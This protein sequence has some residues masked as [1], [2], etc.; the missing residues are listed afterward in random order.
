M[1]TSQKTKIQPKT[2][3][4]KERGTF[5]SGFPCLIKL[6]VDKLAVPSSQVVKAGE[7]KKIFHNTP[8][9]SSFSFRVLG[10]LFFGRRLWLREI[11]MISFQNEKFHFLLLSKQ[12]RRINQE[13]QSR[14]LSFCCFWKSNFPLSWFLYFV[15]ITMRLLAR[16]IFVIVLKSYIFPSVKRKPE[17]NFNLDFTFEN[18]TFLSWFS[19]LWIL[20][21]GWSILEHFDYFDHFGQF[22]II[23]NHLGPFW[24][25][26]FFKIFLVPEV[27]TRKIPT[28]EIK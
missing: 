6:T 14:T 28:L 12:D 4:D 17:Q 1:N 7:L 19:Y 25:F 24:P 11:F 2:T 22:F 8:P 10:F 21:W 3:Q 23:L 18:Q 9:L 5:Y 13:N 26:F 16:D 15:N 27:Y 20:K